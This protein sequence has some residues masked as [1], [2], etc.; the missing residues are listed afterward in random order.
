LL[1]TVVDAMPL[2]SVLPPFEPE[3]DSG[4][5]ALKVPGEQKSDMVP[6]SKLVLKELP[7]MPISIGAAQLPLLNASIWAWESGVLEHVAFWNVTVWEEPDAG[8][9][10]K[11]VLSVMMANFALPDAYR[12]FTSACQLLV[13]TK[14]PSMSGRGHWAMFSASANTRPNSVGRVD[15]VAPSTS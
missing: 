6:F 13:A 1:T 8:L 4:G 10:V 3:Q 7:E 15:W 12:V 2:G 11:L 9:A 5:P 14:V